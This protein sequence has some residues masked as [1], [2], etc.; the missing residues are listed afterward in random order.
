M[1]AINAFQRS[2]SRASS[3][4]TKQGTHP[5]HWRTADK[6]YPHERAIGVMLSA[7]GRAH[8]LTSPIA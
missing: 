3:G 7:F 8:G 1:Q 6:P 5:H 4:K 2:L